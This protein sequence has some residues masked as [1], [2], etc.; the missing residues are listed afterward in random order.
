M[1]E[2]LFR[3]ARLPAIAYLVV[4]LLM[5][6]FERWLVYPAPPYDRS[7]W[8]PG[9]EEFEDVDFQSTDG[10]KL[11]GWLLE[12]D[13][14]DRVVLYFHGNGEQVADNADL[15][16]FL[17]EHLNATVFL[18]DYRGYG[19][20]EGKPH[21]EGLIAD[22]IAAQRWL[23]DRTGK[24]ADE[25]LLVGR[26]IGGGV[27]VACAAELGAEALVL[28][29]TFNRL[30]DAAANHFPWLPVRLLMRN[31]YDSMKRIQ[32]Y[33]GPLFMS[34]G[35]ADSVVPIELGRQLFDAAPSD[36]KEFFEIEDRDH[37]DPQTS[38]YY[39]ALQDFLGSE[40][41]SEPVE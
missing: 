27:A 38:D 37:N 39:H 40:V 30:T 23:A 1:A 33:D 11:H 34:H 4:L 3:I 22:G 32:Q 7:D 24:P 13:Q 17:S 26:S 41:D 36:K 20:S 14:S 10:T 5:T 35:T 19:K 6:C 25:I 12:L 29:S 15:I 21:E 9:G 16:S 28:Q 2:R 31:R 18:F 8:S